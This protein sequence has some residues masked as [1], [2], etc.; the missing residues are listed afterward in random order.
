MRSLGS[1][2]KSGKGNQTV[3][4]KQFVAEMIVEASSSKIPTPPAKYLVASTGKTESGEL[5]KAMPFCAANAHISS[6]K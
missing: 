5:G 6:P 3:Q 4:H 2:P 1:E